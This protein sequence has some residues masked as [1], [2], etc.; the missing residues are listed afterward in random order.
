MERCAVIIVT[1]KIEKN[2]RAHI[3]HHFYFFCVINE[4]CCVTLG[5]NNNGEWD[6]VYARYWR[7]SREEGFAVAICSGRRHMYAC[8]SDGLC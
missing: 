8:L 3:H 2:V 4:C 6:V 1:L 5:S 7:D